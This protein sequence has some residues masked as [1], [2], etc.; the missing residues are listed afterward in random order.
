MIMKAN[1]NM[2]SLQPLL[3]AGILLIFLFADSYAQDDHLTLQEAARILTENNPQLAQRALESQSAKAQYRNSLASYYPSIDFVQSISHSNNPVYVFGSLLNQRQF[4]EANFNIA[5][6]NEPDALTDNVSRFQLG[7]LLYDFGGR[8]NRN[9]AAKTGMEIYGLQ[10]QAERNRLI[11]EL[12]GRYY[13]VSLA[14]QM[15]E[16]AQDTLKS[17]QSR[18]DQSKERVDA[19]LSVES[20][21]LSSEV[22]LSRAKQQLID[23]ENQA[24]LAAASLNELLGASDTN[25]KMTNTMA[26]VSIP[27]NPLSYW[28]DLMVKNRVELQIADDAKDVAHRKVGITNSKFLPSIQ[29]WTNYEWHGESLD[30]TG[31]NWGAGVELKW[32]LFRG[33]SDKS[34]LSSAKYEAQKEEEHYRETHNALRLQVESA[35]YRLQAAKEKYAVSESV[36]KQAEENRRIYAE[37]YASGMVSIQ[38]SLQA[39]ASFSEARSMHMQNLY[40]VHTAYAALLASSGRAEDILQTDTAKGEL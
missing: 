3:M 19:G 17:A 30:Y 9:A 18:R 35:Y 38:D 1:A 20:D 27:T 25:W 34:T 23:A 22:F 2:R 4:T 37:R 14:Q 8:E 29:A 33:F 11:Q 40:E 6:L 10:Y 24:K 26:E 7:W 31:N 12:I 32:N 13:A 5:S 36:L 21:L 16:A 28:I 39:E 15:I